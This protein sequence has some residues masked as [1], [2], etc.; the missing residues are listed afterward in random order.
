MYGRLFPLITLVFS[1]FSL[2]GLGQAAR[3]PYSTFGIGEPYGNA[4]ANTQGM[5]GLGISVPQYWYVNNQNPALLIYNRFTTFQAGMI[6]ESRNIENDSLKERSTNGN[7]NYLVVAFPV[8][9][10]RWTTSVGLMP[11]TSINYRFQSV[12]PIVN[13]DPNNDTVA[14]R[15]TELGS[16]GLNQFYWS[17]GVRINKNFSA[18]VKASYVFGSIENDYS[19]QLLNSGQFILKEAAIEEQLY[20]TDFAFDLGL[21][22]VK[23]GEGR[24][25][26]EM[27]YITFRPHGARQLEDQLSDGTLRLIGLL[28][29]L[30]EKHTAPLLLEEPELSLNEEIVRK[31]HR[32]FSKMSGRLNQQIFITTHSYAL[33]Y[34][35]GIPG[36]SIFKVEPGDDG[37]RIVGHDRSE[38]VA[39]ANGIPPSDVVLSTR[40]QLEFDV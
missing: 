39:M 35:P 10:N 40:P 26:I 7:L 4:T 36:D 13:S 3:S 2:Q 30:Q 23:D 19:N 29:L 17:N 28:W 5:G 25:H 32:I 8:K 27:R 9:I 22:F 33:L 31:L 16:G 24:P 34:N 1:L 18:G 12:E 20:V 14:F 21:A 15:N 38:L 37:S 6:G 11:L